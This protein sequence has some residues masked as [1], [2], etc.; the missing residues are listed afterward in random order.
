[1]CNRNFRPAFFV[2]RYTIDIY[3]VMVVA[4]FILYHMTLSTHVD[5]HEKRFNCARRPGWYVFFSHTV[6]PRFPIYR[7]FTKYRIYVLNKIPYIC[8]LYI[9]IYFDSKRSR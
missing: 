1:M 3:N 8:T 5:C 9:N 7:D 4:T 2:T 6:I